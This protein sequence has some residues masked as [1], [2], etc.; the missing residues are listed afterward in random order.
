M[1]AAVAMPIFPDTPDIRDRIVAERCT[2]A[3]LI[4]GVN[5]VFYDAPGV[6]PE[7]D[8]LPH[9]YVYDFDEETSREQT[10][11]WMNTLFLGIAIVFRFDK[12]SNPLRVAAARFRS[13]TKA[14]MTMDHECGGL[15]S[16][17]LPVGVMTPIELPGGQEVGCLATLWEIKFQ[18]TRGWPWTQ[19]GTRPGKV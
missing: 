19:D 16:N 17:F 13:L 2:T 8:Q 5:R 1:S 3:G 12:E 18:E 7:M 9:A 11:H 15:A 10:A 6:D 14:V 4:P